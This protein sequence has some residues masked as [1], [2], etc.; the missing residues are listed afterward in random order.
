MSK[1]RSGNIPIVYE[2]AHVLVVDKPAGL[3]TVRHA[4]E[5]TE[6][7]TR[8]SVFSPRR[9]LICSTNNIPRRS[10]VRDLRAVHRLD[11]ETSGLVV[12]ALTAEA[13]RQ[14]GLQF[15]AHSVGRTYRALVRGTPT[16]KPSFHT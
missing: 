1:Q 5:R 7:G 2:D 9:W 13:E 16:K 12:L 6:F 3:T 15:R 10:P 14:L 4:S 8:A 11:K